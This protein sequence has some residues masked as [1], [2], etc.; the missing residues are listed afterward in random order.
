[1][2][3]KKLAEGNELFKDLY[4]KKHED[5]L[6]EL[7]KN[8]QSPKALFIGCSDSRVIPDAILQTKP[9]DLFVV[10]NVGN[11]VPPFKPDDDFHSTASAIEYAVSV[12]N[13]SDIIVC[14]HS[15]CGAIEHLF[16]PHDTSKPD[17][18]LIHTYKW[19][20]LAQK[21]KKMVLLS[22]GEEP[23]QEKILRATEKLSIITQLDNLLTYPEVKKRVQEDR[24]F[25]HGWYYDIASGNIRYYDSQSYK[26]LPLESYKAQS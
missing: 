9:G 22:M 20:Q 2:D 17:P 13:V 26:F 6:L 4:F 3:F 21:A 23:D 16:T 25:I 18:A 19:L 14:G 11:F 5:E 24:L 12:L 7:V 15:H 1:M 10:R 8:G